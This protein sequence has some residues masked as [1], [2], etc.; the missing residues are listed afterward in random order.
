MKQQSILFSPWLLQSPG[1]KTLGEKS[2]TIGALLI[3]MGF[4]G[5]IIP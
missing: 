2:D 4:G 3:R 1:D 5:P